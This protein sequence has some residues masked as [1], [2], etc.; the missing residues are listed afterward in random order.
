MPQKN[1]SAAERAVVFE[2]T[3]HKPLPVGQQIFIAGNQPMIGAW[4]PDGFPL[5]RMDD[6]TFW[7]ALASSDALLFAR[8][9]RHAYPDLD[10]TIREV[11]VAPMQIQGPKSVDLMVDLVGDSV[12]DLPY[13]GLMEAKVGGRELAGTPLLGGLDLLALA[14]V[15]RQ[16]RR[17]RLARG[18]ILGR[19]PD[20]KA[21]RGDLDGHPAFLVLGQGAPV[22]GASAYDGRGVAGRARILGVR[23]SSLGDDLVHGAGQRVY[24]T[25]DPG[26]DFLVRAQRLGVDP[27]RGQRSAQPV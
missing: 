16:L 6:N 8:G 4:K 27:Q 13:Y 17:D 9:L 7:F 23:A 26:H 11:D 19:H 25:D 10:V 5:T 22:G 24:V 21:V 3:T 12:R 18:Q 14:Q 20:R 2:V 1:S 15:A